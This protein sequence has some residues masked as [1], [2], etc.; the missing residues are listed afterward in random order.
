M[1]FL[2]TI[3]NAGSDVV[4]NK[5]T[6]TPFTIPTWATALRLQPSAATMSVALKLADD[7][8]FLPASTDVLLIGAANSINDIPI[9]RGIFN[10]SDQVTL[11]VRKSDS[12]A[13]TTKVFAVP[14]QPIFA[15]ER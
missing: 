3:A 1:I 8:S 9:L 6:S 10:P 15:L 2:G 5:T 7:A 4:N 13:G 11:A 12:G 14:A